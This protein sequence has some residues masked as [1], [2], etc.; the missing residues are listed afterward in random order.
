[1]RAYTEQEAD[2]IV[3]DGVVDGENGN[4]QEPTQKLQNCCDSK[5][6]P[7]SIDFDFYFCNCSIYE[8]WEDCNLQAHFSADVAD[9]VE[10]KK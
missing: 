5:H 2:E 10:S 7:T 9:N 1:M 3:I 6:G 4:R 8:G